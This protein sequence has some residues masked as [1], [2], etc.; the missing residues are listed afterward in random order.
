[1]TIQTPP[2]RTSGMP[3]PSWRP[4]ESVNR[5][6]LALTRAVS[7]LTPQQGRVLE[8]GA[9]AARFSRAIAGQLPAWHAHAC[10]IDRV[11][12]LH[13]SAADHNLCVAQADMTALPYT[14]GVFDAVVL[15]D[16]LEHLKQPQPAVRELA[17]VLRPGGILHALV[18]CEGQPATLHWL[19]WKT[20]LA[21]DL[22]E[23]SV[24]HVQR[25][26]H[27][28]LTALLQTN[29][30]EIESVSYSMHWLGQIRDVLLHAEGSRRL[31]R[32]LTKSPLYK[33]ANAALWLAS[34]VESRLLQ[35][36]P[37]TAVAVHVTARREMI[38]HTSSLVPHTS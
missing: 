23:R 13:G 19:M 37:L 2:T 9:G 36:S 10:D 7:A 1:M 21:A 25:F 35:R 24:G 29:G 16:V 22:K 14:S 33:A 8:V 28:S 3:D 20:S 31:P 38:P 6:N 12:L 26:T 5:R 34:Y 15:F 27:Q 30:L 17:R 11:G 4:E 18:P 32:K